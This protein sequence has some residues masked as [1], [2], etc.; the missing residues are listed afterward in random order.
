MYQTDYKQCSINCYTRSFEQNLFPFSNVT[1]NI[2][3]KQILQTSRSTLE[4]FHYELFKLAI[5]KGYYDKE[6]T[7]TPEEIDTINKHY[8]EK[9]NAITT[10]NQTQLKQTF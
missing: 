7:I 1:S 10:S 5:S 4:S 3:L 2:E 9:K 6:K 8:L